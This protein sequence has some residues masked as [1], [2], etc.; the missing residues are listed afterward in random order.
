MK[1][2]VIGDLH[3]RDTWK[4]IVD[5]H[6]L[7]DV[8]YI[9]LGDYVDTHENIGWERQCDNL[10]ALYTFKSEHPDKVVLL[11]G[12]HDLQY[13]DNQL[14]G[15]SGFR[16]N[17]FRKANWMYKEMI[18]NKVMMPMFID[19]FG[20]LFSHAGVS[21]FWF[22]TWYENV[23]PDDVVSSGQYKLMSL[24]FSYDGDHT[25]PYGDDVHQGC[26]WI[27]PKS[28]VSNP[29]EGYRQFV[30]HTPMDKITHIDNIYFCDTLPKEYVKITEKN[31]VKIISLKENC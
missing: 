12:N 8:R 11:I 30:G 16:M 7:N 10:R 25:D 2:I 17:T 18:D 28:L 29:I 6:G 20:N 3:G 21:K 1:Q 27:R 13:Y 15:C 19:E 5:H 24:G 23:T 22:D 14:F 9:F 26:T 4:Y 31:E